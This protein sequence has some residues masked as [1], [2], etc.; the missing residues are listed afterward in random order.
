[1]KNVSE[2]SRNSAPGHSMTNNGPS[3][4]S[5]FEATSIADFLALG[6]QQIT[7]H[8]MADVPVRGVDLVEQFY[9]NVAQLSEL[10]Q[11]LRF[12]NTEIRYLLK[13]DRRTSAR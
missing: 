9:A 5:L 12:M 6:E 8:E 13:A 11:R 10:S 3:S 1:M 4:V 2:N 7:Y